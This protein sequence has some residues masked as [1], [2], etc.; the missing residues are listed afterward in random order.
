MLESLVK[1][2]RAVLKPHPPNPFSVAIEKQATVT[3]KKEPST[4]TKKADILL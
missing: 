1:N 2:Y 3:A 4:M